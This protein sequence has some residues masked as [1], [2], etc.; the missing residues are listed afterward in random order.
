M[1]CFVCLSVICKCLYAFCHNIF[2]L[3][4]YMSSKV[5]FKVGTFT[6]STNISSRELSKPICILRYKL[7]HNKT[8]SCIKTT[9]QPK[10]RC[11]HIYDLISCLTLFSDLCLVLI[12][13]AASFMFKCMLNH[14][15]CFCD[16]YMYVC[17]I[18]CVMCYVLIDVNYNTVKQ[19]HALKLH[20]NLRLDASTSMIWSLGL[21]S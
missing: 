17:A 21:H 11:K 9:H 12:L 20:I 14:N 10:I 6:N 3:L 19:C 2:C 8:M 16:F 13:C 4:I 15:W 5:L 7:Q 1:L 18:L